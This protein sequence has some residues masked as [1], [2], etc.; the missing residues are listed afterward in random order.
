[1]SS[2]FEQDSLVHIFVA[3]AAEGLTKLEAALQPSH[4]NVPTPEALHAEYIVAHRLRGAAS[5][6]GFAG[7]AR[8]AEVLETLLDQG[9]A[10][11][12]DTWPGTVEMVRSLVDALRTQIDSISR[13]GLEED[14][15]F[16]KWKARYPDVTVESQASHAA[17]SS[18]DTLSD[19]YLLP[20]LDPEVFSYFSP[21]AHEY[22]DAIEAALLRLD[23]VPEDAETIQ[24]LFRTAH[25]LKGAA[26]TVGF[27]A[28]GDLTH[29]VEDLMDAI[30]EGRIRMTPTLTDLI[31]RAVDVIRLLMKR[32]A[33]DLERARQGF[34]ALRQ[35]LRQAGEAAAAMGSS[36]TPAAS[37]PPVPAGAARPPRAETDRQEGGQSQKGAAPGEEGA[38]IRVSRERLERLLNL[39]GELVTGRGRLEQRLS[40][41]EQ[42]SHQVQACKVRMIETVRTFEE[43]HTFTLPAPSQGDT[44]A[45]L[46]GFP[47]LHEFGGL[48]FD[49]YDDFNILARRIAEVAADV[50]ES[51]AQLSG[52]IRKAREDMGQ[53]QRLTLGM[54]D[55]IASARMVP[56]GTPFTRFRRAAREMARATGKEVSLVTSGEHT[57]VDTVVV[58]RLVSPLIHLVRN[59]VYHGIEAPADRLARG[60]PAAGTVHLH[61]AHRGNAVVIEVEDDGQGLDVEK[62]KAK[63]V[64][65]GV[66]R[67]E[68]APQLSDAEAIKLI[69]LPGF[70]TAEGVGD[71]AGR[72]VGLD[73]VKRGIEAMNGHIDVETERGVGTKFTLSLPLTLLISTAL[74]VRAGN[75]RFA[76]PLP[77]I[78]EVFMPTP[79]SVQD[80]GGRSVLQVGEEA[81]EVRSLANVLFGESSSTPGL[82]PVVIVRTA[83]ATLGIAVDELL[84]RQEI[85][86]KT[87][88]T[89][90]PLQQSCFG[91]A[92][93]DA[94]GRVIL[95]IDVARLMGGRQIEGPVSLP[96]PLPRSSDQNEPAG[97]AVVEDREGGTRILLID[98]SLSVRKFVGRMLE[99]AGYNV[100]TAIDGEEGLRKASGESYRL[101]ITDLEMP[102]LNGYEVI[103]AL[104]DRPLTKS[105]PILVM[106]T[107]AGEKHRQMA[108]SMGATG[109]LAK[110]VEERALIR[111]VGHWIGQVTEARI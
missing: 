39:V 30:R 54:R 17:A 46:S 37:V 60:K 62:I 34:T 19:R 92:T 6:Y 66:L 23:K 27:Q 89:L 87:L 42:L 86:I 35:Q 96:I 79:G 33:R 67:P 74:L 28:I 7:V 18:D 90:K 68:L 103:Q 82:T 41:L 49:K 55:E 4:G 76:I 36:V 78:R 104:R 21:E 93:I 56:I 77:S 24:H 81:I 20:D 69:F 31:F 111:E 22:L 73:V 25:T 5:L 57:E 97:S 1:M 70:T 102:K 107:R 29:H 105:T 75:E 40:V 58:E 84:G 8:L 85:V 71:Q 14:T 98:D 109:Y 94:E 52:S 38:V 53:L 106:T 32:D 65:L 51:M 88:G 9:L 13:L 61:A 43:K 50:G 80:I 100:D 99:G 48:E 110:P 26:Y 15:C 59:A 83:A 95:V 91:G 16:E 72:G 101:I 45:A 63:A 108:L 10:T 44:Q 47:L 2:E 3:E 64:T 11:S 12:R